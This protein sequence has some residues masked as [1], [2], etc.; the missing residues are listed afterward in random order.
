MAI[1]LIDRF[2]VDIKDFNDYQADLKLKVQL[3]VS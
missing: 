3:S 2:V 1:D